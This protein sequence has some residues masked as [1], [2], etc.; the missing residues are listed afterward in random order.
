[1]AEQA[2]L[3]G[4]FMRYRFS[5]LLLALFLFLAINP[6]FHAAHDDTAALVFFILMCIVVIGN[7]YT[8]TLHA[9]S[10]VI[11]IAMLATCSFLFA[12]S[13]ITGDQSVEVNIYL[14]V[15]L[16]WLYSSGSIL[17]AILTARLVTIDTLAGSVCVYLQIGLIWSIA[18]Y[19]IETFIPGSFNFSA[20][21]LN[22]AESSRVDF[23]VFTYYSFV[24]LTTLGYG[25]YLPVSPPARAFSYLETA[26]GQVFLAVLV[27]R[28]LG[29]H[30][31]RNDR[32]ETEYGAGPS[33]GIHMRG[34]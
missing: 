6:F 10:I 21:P 1:M 16:I 11:G 30:L 13:R 28:L 23:E 2:S 3:S 7:V 31:A 8:V 4:R 26:V 29:L 32:L 12:Y 24:T 27:A 17:M 19:F 22:A 5:L 34:D 20:I 15:G 9:L 14:L 18:F 25:E 33:T